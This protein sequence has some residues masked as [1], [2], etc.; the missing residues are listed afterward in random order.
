MDRMLALYPRRE[1]QRTSLVVLIG[2]FN[3]TEDNLIRYS[4]VITANLKMPSHLE[5]M[6]TSTMHFH[7]MNLVHSLTIT[8][9]P[10]L[11]N[12]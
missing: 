9:R 10:S 5:I 2:W 8:I 12:P 6:V 7:S 1:I 4:L 11:S 3:R